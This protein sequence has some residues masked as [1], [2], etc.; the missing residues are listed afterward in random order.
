[1]VEKYKMDTIMLLVAFQIHSEDFSQVEM[2]Q[3]SAGQEYVVVGP[4][5]LE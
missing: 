3:L 4:G 1:V 2:Y 5:I